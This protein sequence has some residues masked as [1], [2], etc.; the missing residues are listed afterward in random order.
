MVIDKLNKY[1]IKCSKIRGLSDPKKFSNNLSSYI[2][3]SKCFDI[4]N[5]YDQ[6]DKII[7]FVNVFSDKHILKLK[8]NEDFAL[9]QDQLA[10][11]LKQIPAGWGN[12]SK[13][14]L[15]EMTESKDKTVMD[16]LLST[17]LNFMQII[18]KADFKKEISEHSLKAIKSRDFFAQK[19]RPS[20]RKNG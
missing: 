4:E 6:I 2:D 1:S 15:N 11:V 20:S 5:N 18:K 8:L 7:E 17:S 3:Y 14:L 9:T 16:Y 10:F 13:M 19:N 12:L